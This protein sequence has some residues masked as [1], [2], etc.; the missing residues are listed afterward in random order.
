MLEKDGCNLSKYFTFCRR[1]FRSGNSRKTKYLRTYRHNPQKKH[2]SQDKNKKYCRA[3]A[4]CSEPRN[5]LNCELRI[6]KSAIPQ[7]LFEMIS[8]LL[9]STISMVFPKSFMI[10]SF[11]NSERV[12]ITL[13]VLMPIKSAISFLETGRSK[14]LEL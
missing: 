8:S 6:N 9:R 5:Y 3:G 11:L 14:T 1:I 7:P 10:P 13:A 12:L 2:A 4:F